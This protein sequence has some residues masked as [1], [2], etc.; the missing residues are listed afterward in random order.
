MNTTHFKWLVF[1]F[2]S[3]FLVACKPTANFIYSP[4]APSTGEVVKF[5][6]SKTTVYKAD[7]GNAIAVYA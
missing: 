5:D 1:A 6:A 3:L 7:E 2:L 4:S